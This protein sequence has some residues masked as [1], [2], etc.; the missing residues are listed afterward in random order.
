VRSREGRA[1]LVALWLAGARVLASADTEVST[2]AV[3]QPAL[4]AS[5][6]RAAASAVAAD[7]LLPGSEK[8]KSL[9]L[10]D[11]DH[12]KKPRKPDDGRWWL[13]M[14][15]ALSAGL[16]V[17]MWLC[18]AGLLIWV[19]LRLRDWLGGAS[20]VRSL[21]ALPP[22]HVGSLDIRPESLPADIGSAA[23]ALIDRGEQRAALSLLYRGALSRL[24]HGHGVPI[25]AASTENECLALAA[26]RLA[27]ASQTFL[28]ELVASWQAVAYAR[29][30]LPPESLAQL[31]DA[32]DARLQQRPP[33]VSA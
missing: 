14:I 9:R 24:V 28:A 4:S 16:R 26:A 11:K 19:L 3:A 12:E 17:A 5:A 10:K 27:P 7:P 32:F 13:D 2:G 23:R 15:G 18:V 6:V 1:W 8:T 31:C 29:R 21:A 25:R 30:L 33:G 20:G 22:T